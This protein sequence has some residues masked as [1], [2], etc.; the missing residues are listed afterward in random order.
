MLEKFEQRFFEWLEEASD[1][2][3]RGLQLRQS[4]ALIQELLDGLGLANADIDEQLDVL[5]AAYPDAADKARAAVASADAA[6]EA[7][8]A[9]KAAAAAWRDAA[10][11]IN[12][13]AHKHIPV[14]SLDGPEP[15][16]WR[17]TSKRE[18]L[19]TLLISHACDLAGTD[20]NEFREK[21]DTAAGEIA[22]SVTTAGFACR[23]R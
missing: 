22:E 12:R 8:V 16:V 5:A 6:V 18:V 19:L 23:Y 21:A 17:D 4:R 20:F 13:D 9:A 11:A 1:S 2:E 14:S 3:I 10:N 7:I 15:V